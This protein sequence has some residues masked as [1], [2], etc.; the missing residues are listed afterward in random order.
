MSNTKYMAETALVIQDACNASGV[1][2]ALE[3]FAAD[4][5]SDHPVA[6][7]FADKLDDLCGC[8]NL[9]PKSTSATFVGLMAEFKTTMERLC[10]EPH[11]TD[12]RNQH[13]DT[14]DLVRQ[15]VYLT[16]SRNRFSSA[17]DKCHEMLTPTEAT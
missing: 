13:P 6:A 8:R 14:Q 12:W 5:S 7:L 9:T 11:G 15:L 4:L 1:V 17:Y 10:R 3:R 2:Y 16:D